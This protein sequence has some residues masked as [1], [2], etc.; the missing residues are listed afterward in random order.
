MKEFD[1]QLNLPSMF[2]LAIIVWLMSSA[3]TLDEAVALP[4]YRFEWEFPGFCCL[5]TFNLT[6]C[7]LPLENTEM[8]KFRQFMTDRSQTKRKSIQILFDKLNFATH[9]FTSHTLGR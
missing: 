1:V 6:K 8:P 4:V 3:S 7:G 5:G 2:Q 9:T